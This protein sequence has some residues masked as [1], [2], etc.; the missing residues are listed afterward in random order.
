M[1]AFL[2]SKTSYLV[3]LETLL[4]ET[5][6]KTNTQAFAFSLPSSLYQSLD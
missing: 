3:F 1:F 4:L 2:T 6:Q 5:L